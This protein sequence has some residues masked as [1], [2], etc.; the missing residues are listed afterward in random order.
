MQPDDGRPERHP[1]PRGLALLEPG[2]PDAFRQLGDDV[3]ELLLPG[4][5]VLFVP[6]PGTERTRVQRLAYLLGTRGLDRA[7]GLVKTQ[8]RFLET[9]GVSRKEAAGL[10]GTSYASLTVLL[11]RASK[12]KGGTRART[13]KR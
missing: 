3:G 4:S 5:K 2:A 10:L 13:K 1:R 9:L 11:G 8:A 12:K 6:T 7:L